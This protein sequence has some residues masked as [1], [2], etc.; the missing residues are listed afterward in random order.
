MYELNTI[1]SSLNK[2][3]KNDWEQTRMIAYIIA[4]CNSSKQL[5]VTDILKFDWDNDNHDKQEI[6]TQEDVARLKAKATSIA[7]T[8]NTK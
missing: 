2:S 6:I 3:I 7:K 8:L 5:K 1:L 4:Q